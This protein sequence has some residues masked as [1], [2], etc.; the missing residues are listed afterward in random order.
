M[1]VNRSLVQSE[2]LLPRLL[3]DAPGSQ[4][5]LEAGNKSMKHYTIPVAPDGSQSAQEELRGPYYE[6]M[7]HDAHTLDFDVGGTKI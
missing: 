2:S 1:P 6:E 7:S 4:N 3:V 5:T